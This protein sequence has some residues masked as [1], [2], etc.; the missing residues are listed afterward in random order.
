MRIISRRCWRAELYLQ[1]WYV[2]LNDP[3]ANQTASVN[4]HRLPK[5]EISLIGSSQRTC[6]GILTERESRPRRCII[7]AFFINRFF[8]FFLRVPLARGGRNPRVRFV[9]ADIVDLYIVHRSYSKKSG[10]HRLYLLHY[11]NFALWTLLSFPRRL[12]L[13]SPVF[14]S[15]SLQIIYFS[16][17][18]NR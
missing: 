16:R 4:S 18:L 7:S 15:F 9:L 13:D 2:V 14:L 8:F 1:L 5:L 6:V 12:D 17:E 10:D 3:R 11:F